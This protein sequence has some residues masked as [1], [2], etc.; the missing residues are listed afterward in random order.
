MLSSASCWGIDG[1]SAPHLFS[2]EPLY[3]GRRD[4]EA[5]VPLSAVEPQKEYRTRQLLA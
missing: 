1:E 4:L 5:R 2:V 3:G